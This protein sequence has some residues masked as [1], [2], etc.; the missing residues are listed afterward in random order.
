MI[1][2]Y[3]ISYNLKLLFTV[4][5]EAKKKYFKIDIL[6]STV[7]LGMIFLSLLNH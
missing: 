4:V 7:L 1:K 2:T 3:R 5:H 6:N